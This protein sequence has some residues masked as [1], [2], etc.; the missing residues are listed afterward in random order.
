MGQ[1]GRYL[2]GRRIGLSLARRLIVEHLR[3]SMDVPTCSLVGMLDLAPLVAARSQAANRPAWT[4]IFAKAQA[5]AALEVPQLRRIFVKLPWPHVYE[6][7]SS[8]ASVVV[9]REIDGEPALLYAL[10]KSPEALPLLAVTERIRQAKSAPLSEFKNLR[11]ALRLARL[12][13]PMRRL[14][15]WMARNIGRQAP[16][17]FGTYGISTVVMDGIAFPNPRTHWTSFLIYGPI[18]A[19]GR[20][21]LNLTFDHRVLDGSHSVAAFRALQAALSGPILAEL[22]ALAPAEAVREGTH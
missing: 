11:L 13:Q 16:N 17:Q 8:V 21:E 6:L 7:P 5:L 3:L 15:V 2:K 14:L 4:A 10:I 18:G 1:G 19:D 9:E 20:M 22:Q 12:P